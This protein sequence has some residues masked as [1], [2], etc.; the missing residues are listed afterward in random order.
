[1]L[2]YTLVTAPFAGIVTEKKVDEGSMAVPGGPIVVLEETERYRIEAS[3]PETY[4]GALNVGS[5]VRVILD[6]AG[7]EEMAGAVSEV[8]P[9]VDPGSRTFTVKADLP[10]GAGMRTGMF[11]RVLFPVGTDTVLVVP[12]RAVSPVGGYDALYT[13]SADNVARLVMIRTGRTFGNE[14]EILSGIGPG[15]RVAVSPLVRLAD[16]VRVEVRK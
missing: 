12:R 6:G 5:R 10:R 2:S 1:M 15:T 8:V 7:G 16:G 4:L 9:T 13:V 11:G 14:V 3:V